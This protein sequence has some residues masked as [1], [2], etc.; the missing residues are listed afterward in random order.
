M[1]K[2]RAKPIKILYVGKRLNISNLKLYGKYDI[3]QKNLPTQ[4]AT[5]FF[6]FTYAAKT[7]LYSV[8]NKTIS[9]GTKTV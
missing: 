9:H 6:A 1:E 8:P 4:L 7:K 5:T 3:K 2:F